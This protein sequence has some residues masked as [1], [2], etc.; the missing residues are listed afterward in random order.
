[1]EE[2]ARSGPTARSTPVA[3]HVLFADDGSTA[4]APARRFALMLTAATGARLTAVYVRDPLESREEGHR[5]LAVTLSA[6]AAAGHRCTAVVE[7]PVGITNPGRRI[8]AAAARCRADVIVVG[9]RGAGLARKLLGSVSSYVI[10]RA[11]IS[12]CVV[13]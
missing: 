7:P 5:K 6:A 2:A 12:V 11:R 3:R 1:M 10:S 4:A 8:L 9:A 13:R